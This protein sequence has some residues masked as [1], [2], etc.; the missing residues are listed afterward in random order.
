MP[1]INPSIFKAYDVRG[2]YP[3]ELNEQAAY[4]IGRAFAR[5]FKIPKVIVGRDA[6]VMGTALHGALVR[7]FT[8]AGVDVLDI[9]LITTDMLYFASGKLNLPGLS[10]TG[11][12]NPPEYDGIKMVRAGAVPVSGDSGINEIRDIVLELVKTPPVAADKKGTVESLDVLGDYVDHILSFIDLSLIKP[13]RVVVHTHYGIG[14]LVVKKLAERLPLE[15]VTL[16]F[17][18]DGR[19]PKGSPNPLLPERRTE[20]EELVR[21]SG[22]DFGVAWDGDADRCFFLDE[23]G[24]FIEGYYIGTMLAEYLI[25]RS[26]RKDEKV[27]HCPRLSWLFEEVVREAGGVSLENKVGHAFI[28][29]TMRREDALFAEEM[30]GHYYFRDNYYADNGMIPFLLVLELVSKTGKAFSELARAYT[31]RMA[32]SGELNFEVADPKAAM[33]KVKNF[34]EGKG[35]EREIDGVSFDFG[36]PPEGWRFNLRPSNTEP[37]TRLNVESV[38]PELVKEKTEEIKKILGA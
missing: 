3:S 22:V 20:T 31:S 24:N 26:G 7:G 6:R 18:V 32:I 8:D 1:E 15:L 4:L 9:G 38:S 29:E 28:K 14:S 36:L 12:H 5:E 34:Y 10:V 25:K 17:E 21:R 19:F 23:N 33:V 35:K 30:S 11:S 2:K 13:A 37:L 16:D 27:I